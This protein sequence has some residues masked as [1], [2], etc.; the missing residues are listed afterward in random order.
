[1]YPFYYS[2]QARIKEFSSG[3]SNLPKN[4]EKQKKKKKWGGGFSIYSALVWSKSILA[5]ETALQT[6][7]FFNNMTC[8]GVFPR[9]IH[10]RGVC[11][12]FVQYGS[13]F[14]VEGGGGGGLGVFPPKIFCL[15]CVKS[16]YFRQNKHGNCTFM[17]A[18]D[19]V[20]DGRRANPF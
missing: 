14:T 12:S 20:Y 6:I 13:D 10:I 5:I 4:F 11:F 16:Y 9:Q 3:G 7:F 1:M 2:F 19:S 8:R 17:E 18:R 15:S